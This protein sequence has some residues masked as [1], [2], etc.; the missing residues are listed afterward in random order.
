MDSNSNRTQGVV[1]QLH[2]RVHYTR[3]RAHNVL[4]MMMKYGGTI[5]GLSEKVGNKDNQHK[6]KQLQSLTTNSSKDKDAHT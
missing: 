4:N 6:K 5:K 2:N 3:Y 1:V